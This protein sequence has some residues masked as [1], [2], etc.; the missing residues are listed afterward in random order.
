MFS[1]IQGR[2]NCNRSEIK[3]K[4]AEFLVYGKKLKER[5]NLM[6]IFMLAKTTAFHNTSTIWY[7][8]YMRY[9]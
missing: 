9:L 7:N 6:R 3:N 1:E 2:D 5:K 4:R 8:I